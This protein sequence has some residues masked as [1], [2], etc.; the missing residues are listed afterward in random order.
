MRLQ[1]NN[2]NS[3]RRRVKS[4]R[5]ESRVVQLKFCEAQRAGREKFF[6][7]PHKGN[8]YY[9]LFVVPFFLLRLAVVLPP[10]LCILNVPSH[11]RLLVYER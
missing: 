4:S 8:R 10:P 9:R 6:S 3:N 7:D 2:T 1:S 5:A 11:G